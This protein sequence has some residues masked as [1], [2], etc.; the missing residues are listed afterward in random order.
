MRVDELIKQ[1][2]ALASEHGDATPVYTDGDDLYDWEIYG[3][4]TRGGEAHMDC[5]PHRIFLKI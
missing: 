1:L 2:V 5:Q 3:V 4:E